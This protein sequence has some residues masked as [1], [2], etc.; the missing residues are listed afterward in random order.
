M[1]TPEFTK[2]ENFSFWK[3]M[4]LVIVFFALTPITLGVSLFSLVSLKTSAIATQETVK[5]NQTASAFSGVQVY[6]ALPAKLPAV[7]GDVGATDARPEIVRQYLKF[8]KSPLVPY[9]DLVIQ[10]SDKYG[11]DYR[12]LVAIAQQESN[13]CK[14][15]PPESYNCWGWGINSHSNLGFD[16]YEESL[17]VVAKGLRTQ[18]LDKG[19]N[20][21]EEIMSKYNP[22]SP[23]GAWAKG[24]SQFMSDME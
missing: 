19:Y 21:V 13:L 11:L 1:Q 7:S 12:L 8:Y 10:T 24:V 20:T 22:I 9:T 15:I 6:A 2:E 23:N 4:F 16:S 17:D 18:Y 3:N 14:V 5:N